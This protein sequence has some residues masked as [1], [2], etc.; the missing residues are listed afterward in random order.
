[1][2]EFDGN[3]RDDIPPYNE[4]A[5][6]KEEAYPIENS[7]DAFFLFILLSFSYSLPLFDN[8]VIA[9]EDWTHLKEDSKDMLLC[10]RKGGRDHWETYDANTKFVFVIASAIRAEKLTHI[11]CFFPYILPSWPRVVVIKLKDMLD[12]NDT[13]D[14][15]KVVSLLVFLTYLM[16]FY[17]R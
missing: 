3:T 10:F 4:N 16:R 9:N 1:M 5:T 13:A 12:Q 15:K 6:S 14:R 8:A 17:H 7:Y 2:A 11:T